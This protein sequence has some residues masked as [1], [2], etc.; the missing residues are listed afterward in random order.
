MIRCEIKVLYSVSLGAA[1]SRIYE[2]LAIRLASISHEIKASGDRRERGLTTFR[3]MF[4]THPFKALVSKLLQ[5]TENLS[6]F[7]FVLRLFIA[8]LI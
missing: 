1:F 5:V 4:C 3:W 8:R 7:L 6:V 2:G